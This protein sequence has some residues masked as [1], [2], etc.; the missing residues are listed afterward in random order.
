M[1][2]QQ[3]IKIRGLN[4]AAHQ[5]MVEQAKQ[6]NLSVNKYIEQKLELIANGVGTTVISRGREGEKELTRQALEKIRMKTYFRSLIYPYFPEF[7]MVR[8]INRN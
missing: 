1:K 5:H 4:K 2:E 6:S 7:Q 8:D 3:S